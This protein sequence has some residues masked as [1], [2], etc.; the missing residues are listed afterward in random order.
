MNYDENRTLA[1]LDDGAATMPSATDPHV[2]ITLMTDRCPTM[3]TDSIDN[4]PRDLAELKR[5]IQ[6][7]WPEAAG[8]ASERLNLAFPTGIPAL[9]RLFPHRG[10]PCGQL[11]EITGGVSSG[12]TTLLFTLLAAFGRSGRAVYLDLS[13]SFFPP[14][15]AA[16]G[17][18]LDRL[19]AVAPTTVPAALRVA[20][21][22]LQHNTASWIALDLVGQTETLPLIMLHRLRL[23]VTRTRGLILFLTDNRRAILPPSMTAL[24]LEITRTSPAVIRIDITKS[25]LCREGVAVEIPCH[26]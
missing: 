14:A 8:L 22:L 6:R 10:I 3:N 17:V 24:R 26:E 19:L 18:D 20:E 12:K 5:L 16:C 7:K 2:L 13:R 25:R 21:L 4:T 15:A 23:K 9:D 11:I 1:M